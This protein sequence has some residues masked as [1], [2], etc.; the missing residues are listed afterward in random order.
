MIK[1]N[2]LRPAKPIKGEDEDGD[3]VE[4][5][6]CTGYTR[7]NGDSGDE[8]D[9]SSPLADSGEDSSVE[10]SVPGGYD[11]RRVAYPWAHPTPAVTPTPS[12]RGRP[13][14]R[15]DLPFEDSGSDGGEGKFHGFLAAGRLPIHDHIAPTEGEKLADVRSPPALARETSAALSDAPASNR[16]STTWVATPMPSGGVRTASFGTNHNGRIFAL[17]RAPSIWNAFSPTAPGA[18]ARLH[19]LE[20]EP[21]KEEAADQLQQE[22]SDPFTTGKSFGIFPPNSVVRRF[23]IRVLRNKYF[24]VLIFLLIWFSAASAIVSVSQKDPK[25][26]NAFNISDFVILAIFVV[27][28]LLKMIAQGVILNP[29]SYFRSPADC[30]DFLLVVTACLAFLG[31]VN[32]IKT[33]RLFRALRPLRS[34]KFLSGV[35]GI[36]GS[37]QRTLPMLVDNVLLLL[38]CFILFGAFAVEFYRYS[39]SRVCVSTETG[40]T[41]LPTTYCKNTTSSV[42]FNAGCSEGFQCATVQNPNYGFSSFDNFPS[43]MLVMFQIVT[44]DGWSGYMFA[45][46]DAELYMPSGLWFVFM[47]SVSVFVVVNLFVAVITGVFS[48]IR[49]ES[50]KSAFVSRKKK[51]NANDDD[52]AAQNVVAK[53]LN[54]A[55]EVSKEAARRIYSFVPPPPAVLRKAAK[56]IMDNTAFQ[57]VVSFTILCTAVVQSMQYDTMSQ[58]YEDALAKL[59]YLFIGLFIFEMAVKLFALGIWGYFR[60]LWNLFDAS[61]VIASIVNLVVQSHN[62]SFLRVVRMMRVLRLVQRLED[63]RFIIRAALKGVPPVL[64]LCA[65]ATI[66]MLIFAVLGYQ[67]FNNQLDKDSRKTFDGFFQSL[68]TLFVIM[69][70]Q[71]ISLTM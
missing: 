67:L 10:Y 28:L 42:V 47:I 1:E 11:V 61:L 31:D 5:E 26:T 65:F 50:H 18:A 2:P 69:T 53:Q 46:Q 21:L 56:W 57:F 48:R 37:L 29:G 52:E 63:L 14:P 54:R 8:G 45:L 24:R 19:S 43:A 4:V 30:L 59:D 15:L 49:M 38:F 41:M 39:L 55:V 27:E 12:I 44:L 32:G 7:S 20:P 17:Q 25:I 23:A 9:V 68:L 40:E 22:A 6:L 36:L 51:S 60:V 35:V 13:V 70:V 34:V 33:L 58:S 64:N 62:V 16:R 3:H 66:S 71:N